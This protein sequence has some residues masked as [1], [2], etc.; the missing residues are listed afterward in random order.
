[1]ELQI[2]GEKED[3]EEIEL[4]K[5]GCGISVIIN[6]EQVAHFFNDGKF[7]FYGKIMQIKY[8]GNWKI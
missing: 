1:M 7:E 3:K 8:A 5:T 6:K 4:K 2:K